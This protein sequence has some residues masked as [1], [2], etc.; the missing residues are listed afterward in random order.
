MELNKSITITTITTTLHKAM[1]VALL[2]VEG[3][4]K[5]Y[6]IIVT[7]N[8]GGKIQIVNWHMYR[9]TAKNNLGIFQKKN[10]F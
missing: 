5:W 7:K 3:N 8:N 1:E 6:V 4:I 2:L 10:F 9:I